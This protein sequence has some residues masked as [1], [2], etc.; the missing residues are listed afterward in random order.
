V[1]AEKKPS[2]RLAELRAL[3]PV[4]G[5][6]FLS[7]PVNRRLLQMEQEAD[8]QIA[9]RQ[10]SEATQIELAKLDAV[11]PVTARLH[12]LRIAREHQAAIIFEQANGFALRREAERLTNGQPEPD[13]PAA[14]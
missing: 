10:R 7:S 14:A 6:I 8:E 1:T 3:S 11:A 12:R 5:D 2:E 4:L 9:E 13:P